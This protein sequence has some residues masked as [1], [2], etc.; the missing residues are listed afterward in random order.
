MAIM[1]FSPSF[2]EEIKARL[3][4]S[5][6]VRSRVKLTKAGREWR[7]L[8]PFTSEKTPSFFVNDQK[9][10]WFDFSAGRNGNIFDF[11]MAT[12]GLS[13]AEAVERLAAMAGLAVPKPSREAEAQEKARA[14][15]H[16]V[17]EHAALYF[18][19]MLAGRGG[20]RAR[21]YLE[22]R[23]V[24]P[25]YQARFRLGFAPDEKYALRDHLA[26]KG[27]SAATMIEAG[28]LVHG[29]GIA[30]P[31]DRFRDR[32]MFPISNPAG[33]VIAFGGRALAKDARAKYLN[34]PETGLFHK[35]SVLYNT[36]NARKAAYETGRVIAVEGYID[37]IAMTAAGFPEVVA[38]MGTALT[39]E[40][41]AL[42]W[43]MADI[44]TL[45]FDGDRA[46]RQA[47]YRAIDTALPLVAAGRSLAFALLP[48]GQDPDDFLRSDEP[49][50]MAERLAGA[51]PLVD[52][53]F[54]RETEAKAFTTP[55][56][57]AGLE[58]RLLEVARQIGDPVLRRY[59]EAEFA[60]RLLGAFGPASALRP[61][62]RTRGLQAPGAGP[63]ATRLATREALPPGR[64][65]GP[66]AISASL[67]DSPLLR[68]ARAALPPREG[69]ILLLV[70]NH[71]GLLE[72]H[73]EALAEAELTNAELDALRVRLLSQVGSSAVVSTATLRQAAEAAGLAAITRKL[74]SLAA[75]ASHWYAKPDAAEADAEEVLKQ[76]LTLH[77]RAKALHREL[78]MAESALGMDCS[79]ASL[80][81]LKDIREQLTT[82]GG[83][84]ASIEGFGVLSGRRG[85]IL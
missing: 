74:D 60:S 30:V 15:L 73:A 31:Y 71:P 66:P 14:G 3:A 41:C 44:P 43:R 18:S 4:V 70:L 49:G 50:A 13:F 33:K 42:L 46:G 63:K 67:R 39:P 8:S 34:S 56:Q 57:K 85:G 47:A 72:R 45:C 58:R 53:V 10:A 81:R 24:T 78:Q 22:G 40:H 69:L 32:I 9:G 36:H 1:R 26:G 65:I 16:E 79:E 11:V 35:G 27:A 51:L 59:Y 68:P 12:E 29:E 37:V 7:G 28:L 64:A 17:L 38:P 55:E 61:Q 5:E 82:L 80:G 77:R 2:L 21:A 48:E 25:E 83:T 20:A 54:L 52:L 75:H 62:R 6:V 19:A 84:E 23:G 76:A